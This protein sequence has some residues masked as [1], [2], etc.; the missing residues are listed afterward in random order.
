MLCGKS[1]C[2]P[3]TEK[4]EG[5]SAWPEK[6]PRRRRYLSFTKSIVPSLIRQKESLIKVGEANYIRFQFKEN[7]FD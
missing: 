7:H 4:G 6:A 2:R 5:K 1:W 3:G